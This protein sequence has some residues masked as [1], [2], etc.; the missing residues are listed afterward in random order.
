MKKKTILLFLIEGLFVVGLIFFLFVHISHAQVVSKYHKWETSSYF[1]GFNILNDSPKNL[2][3]IIDLKSTDANFVMIGCFGFREVEAPFNI[4]DANIQQIDSM[5]SYCRQTGVYYSIAVRQ[6]PGRR[7][8]YLESEGIAP[9]ST[10][11]TNATEQSHYAGMC[12]EI[13][14]RYNGDTLFVGLNLFVE[15]NPLF[16]TPCIL[17]PELLEQCMILNNINV[18]DL[19]ALCI[20]S[21]RSIDPDLPIIV[22]N[23]QYSTPEY[24]S[25]LQPQ[26]DPFV[27]YD[28]H[29]YVP[30]QYVKA[31]TANSVAYPGD[32]LS[33]S[34]LG[35]A[36]YD[37]SFLENQTFSKVVEFQQQTG[38]PIIMGEFGLL[39][40]QIGGEQYLADLTDIAICNGWH[41]AYWD[42]RRP[43]SDWD[44]EE[45]GV[46]YWDTVKYSFIKDCSTNI[47]NLNNMEHSELI[48]FPNPSQHEINIDF[49]NADADFLKTISI[50][51][52]SGQLIFSIE[53]ID[54]H[55]SIVNIS[56]LPKGYYWLKVQSSRSSF[57]KQ[58]IK[59]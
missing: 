6:G 41:F 10:I 14:E 24:F 25:I 7:D 58:I 21:V 16:N 28:F 1:R 12:G 19:M 5:V 30:Q 44:Y 38:S 20:D 46:N 45:W 4:V 54:P 15:P 8:V 53:A 49:K 26:A 13:A 55:T 27:I 52:L 18:R 37:R 50:F 48:V 3:D 42:Y 2:Q 9:Q 31:D 57:A 29:N 56:D 23:V 47:M 22:A 36:H 51:N 39:H 33:I 35:I 59:T 17:T 11:W 32:Y 40:P 34:T 43:G